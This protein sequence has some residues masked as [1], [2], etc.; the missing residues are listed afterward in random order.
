MA[1][2]KLYKVHVEDRGNY[3]YARISAPTITRSMALMYLGEIVYACAEMRQKRLLLDRD[4]P[5]VMPDNDMLDVMKE[6]VRMGSGMRVA[7]VNKH[8]PI[9]DSLRRAMSVG[10]EKGADFNYF[11]D[12]EE[13]KQWLMR[14]MLPK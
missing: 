12:L 8:V 1:N 13:A 10:A 3:A 9:T 14:E 5:D 6:F 4:I 11:S 7:L 2:S